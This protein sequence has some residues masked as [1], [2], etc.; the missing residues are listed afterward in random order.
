MRKF[1]R[2]TSDRASAFD[3]FGRANFM[4]SETSVFSARDAGSVPM[5]ENRVTD[6][7][8][9]ILPTAHY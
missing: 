3:R 1:Y 5:L 6:S 7:I 8:H 2:Q 9:F 4:I